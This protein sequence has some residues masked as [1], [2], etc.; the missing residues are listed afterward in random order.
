MPDDPLSRDAFSDGVASGDATFESIVLWTRIVPERSDAGSDVQWYI[1][2]E[3][4]GESPR[5]E[6]WGN[7]HAD[8]RHDHCIRVEIDGLT[9]GTDYTYGFRF[10]EAH[11]AGRTRTLPKRADR[12]RFV[13]ACCSRW[14]WSGF[15]LFE[16]IAG[17][18]ASLL[19]H[20]GDSIYEIG[21]T[22]PNGLT[23]DP[24][25][26]CH[27]LDDY[28]RRHRQYRSDQRLRGLFAS[29]PVLAVW[30]DHEVADNAPDPDSRARRRAGQ[31][32]WTEWMPSRSANVR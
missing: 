9:P 20:L 29:M 21:E 11:I 28:R 19:V 18:Q 7:A 24:P 10:G 8:A 2:A 27:T 5:A 4:A 17:E 13:V 30:D 26:D 23:T 31:Q 6:Q 1:T 16:S 3:G 15:D 25:H 22:L 12:F 14:G 32:A